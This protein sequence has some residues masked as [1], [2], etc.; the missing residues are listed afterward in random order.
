MTSG[1][2]MATLEANIS[3]DVFYGDRHAVSYRGTTV[4]KHESSLYLNQVVAYPV[5]YLPT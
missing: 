1:V 5:E 4:Q 3:T 2:S